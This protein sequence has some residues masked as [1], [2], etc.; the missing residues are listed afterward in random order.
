MSLVELIKG[1]RHIY[2]FK[3]GKRVVFLSENEGEAYELKEAYE[4]V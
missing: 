1:P 4:R 2:Q 3:T